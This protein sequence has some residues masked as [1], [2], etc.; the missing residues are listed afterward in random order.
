M[1][2]AGQQVSRI[3]RERRECERTDKK[4]CVTPTPS[5]GNSRIVLITND[6]PQNSGVYPTM[7]MIMGQL[8]RKLINHSLCFL[9]DSPRISPKISPNRVPNPRCLSAERSYDQNPK[10]S[11]FVFN[12]IPEEEF[13]KLT[14]RTHDLYDNSRLN[15]LSRRL[16]R[17]LSC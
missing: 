10:N 2:V 12:R 7:F 17:W 9:K 4:R 6:R 14:H 5:N 16:G 3:H 1:Q 15:S 8:V 11:S 13:R